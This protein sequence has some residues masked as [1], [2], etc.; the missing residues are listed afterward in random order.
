MGL[1]KELFQEHKDKE[2]QE[3][4]EQYNEMLNNFLSETEGEKRIASLEKLNK[5]PIVERMVIAEHHIQTK[6]INLENSVETN[7]FE[8]NS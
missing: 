2:Y 3:K 1:T 6:K 4:Q 7:I 5:L 8:S